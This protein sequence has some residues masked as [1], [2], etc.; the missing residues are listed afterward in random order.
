MKVSG[1]RRFPQCHANATYTGRIL[2]AS[3]IRQLTYGRRVKSVS[4]GSLLSLSAHYVPDCTVRYLL[5]I[6]AGP[7]DLV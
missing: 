2:M 4:I 6:P 3:L 1:S 7:A 5:V